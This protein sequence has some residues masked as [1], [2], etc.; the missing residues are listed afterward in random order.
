MIRQRIF[1]LAITCLCAL[2]HIHA[3]TYDVQIDNLRYSVNTETL[4]AAAFAASTDI[5][6]DIAIPASIEAAPDGVMR[7]YAVTTIGDYAFYFCKSL[8]SVTIPNSIIT[9]GG[10]AFQ[11]CTSLASITIPESVTVIG[12]LAFSHCTSLKSIEVESGNPNYTSLD[13]VL[14]NKDMTT[15]LCC[16]GAKASID[17]PNSVTAIGNSAFTA[18]IA[19]TSVT[20]PN[21]VDSIGGWAFFSC[22]S[23]TSITIPEKVISIEVN[24]FYRCS[25]LASVA[26]PES[27]TSIKTQAFNQCTA[28]ESITIPRSVTVIEEGAFYGC[29]NLKRIYCL[30]DAPITCD[31]SIWDNAHYSKA[32]LYVPKGCT[33]AYKATTPWSS[34]SNVEEHSISGL[35][36][37]TAVG[38]EAKTAVE[39]YDISGKPVAPDAKGL[40]IVRYSDGSVAKV[41]NHDR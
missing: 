2:I 1:L 23:L 29:T 36:P 39:A 41:L 12:E 40:V 28:L 25:S 24:T 27:L 38:N 35:N 3:A 6:G 34:F 26:L 20:L 21:S 19:L 15:L 32:T 11:Y 9:I 22:V 10:A 18:C 31:P 7:T 5:S 13:G 17:I 30:W 8:A 37:A 33:E 16:P 14:Y 4:E